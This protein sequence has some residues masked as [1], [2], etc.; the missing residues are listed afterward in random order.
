MEQ[1]ISTKEIF[2]YTN[3]TALIGIISNGFYPKYNFEFTFLSDLFERKASYLAVPMVS[4]CD[5]PL[6]AVK[7]HS[8]KYGE[9]A[10]GLRKEWAEKHGLSPVIYINPNSIIADSFAA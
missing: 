5:I 7:K 2:H 3:I 10:I 1:E 8:N 9:C 4:F 6:K